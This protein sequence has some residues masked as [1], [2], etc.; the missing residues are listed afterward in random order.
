M[1]PDKPEPGDVW[2]SADGEEV[3]IVTS[4]S[5]DCIHADGWTAAINGL[6]TFTFRDERAKPDATLNFL[7]TFP[8]FIFRPAKA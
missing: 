5:S 4:V 3:A 8:R 7:S 6:A 1:M 2:A